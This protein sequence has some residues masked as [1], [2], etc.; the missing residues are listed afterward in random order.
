[1]VSNPLTDPDW[2]QRTVAVIDRWVSTV[3]RWT[4]QP[5]VTV[6]R[7]LVFGFLAVFGAVAAIVLIMLGASRALHE[8][9]DAVVDRDAAVWIGYLIVSALLA[10]AGMVLMRKRHSPPDRSS[11]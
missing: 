5:I 3:R 7:G 11:T 8:A 2:A 6:A 4:T 1:M 9:L 10:L